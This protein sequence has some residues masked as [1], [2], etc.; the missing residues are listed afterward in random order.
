MLQPNPTMIRAAFTP[1]LPQKGVHTEWGQQY[2]H[3]KLALDAG[4]IVASWPRQIAR[5]VVGLPTDRR[6]VLHTHLIDDNLRP[7][8]QGSQM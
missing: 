7:E 2:V 1:E 5:G 8:T 4:R 3:G 6:Y